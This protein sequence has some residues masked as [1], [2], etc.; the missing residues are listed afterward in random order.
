[1]G[2]NGQITGLAAAREY[3]KFFRDPITCMRRVYKRHGPVAALGSVVFGEPRKPHVLAVGPE[4]NRQVLGDPST[5]RTTGQFI[6]GPA[7]S[8]QR[9]LR[10]GLTRMVGPE[11]KRQRQLVMPPFHKKAI[12]GYHA[13]MVDIAQNVIAEWRSGQTYDM[14]REVRVL[15]LRISSTILFSHD[16]KEASTIGALLEEWQH[17]N[18]STPVWVLPLDL[19]GTPFRRLL[20]HAEELEK[21]ILSMVQRRRANPGGTDV[22]SLLIQERDDESRGMTDAELVGQS[23]ILFGASFET[24]ASTLTWTLFLLAQHPEVMHK[25]MNELDT[26]LNGAPPTKDQLAQLVYLEWVIK[27]SMRVLPPV[28]FTIRATVR[29]ATI[30]PFNVPNGSR[31]ICSHYMTHHLPDIYPEPERFQPE[32]WRDI[33]PTQYEYMPFSAGPRACIGAMFAIQVLKISLAVMLQKFR[34]KVVPGALIDRVV[35]ITMVPR[36]GMPMSIL[37]N[38]RNYSASPVTGPIHEMVTFP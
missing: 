31:V 12:E 32:R 29:D 22:L 2:T 18:F 24:T 36:H 8:A 33:D 14:L 28:P 19:P 3:I 7:D 16:P 15:T 11:H 4:F 23:T 26:V 21:E 1:M 37:S 10:F 13:I 6:R 27:E 25:L 20:K 35:R 34:F 17:R 5:F 9:R 38:D 30:G